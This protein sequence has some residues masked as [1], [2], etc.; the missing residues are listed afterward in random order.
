MSGLKNFGIKNFVLEIVRSEEFFVEKNIRQKNFGSKN[1]MSQKCLYLKL[2]SLEIFWSR[3][4]GSKQNFDQNKR[5]L[6]E[7]GGR[8]GSCKMGPARRFFI[9]ADNPRWSRVWQLLLTPFVG[10][11]D[12]VKPGNSSGIKKKLNSAASKYSQR[13]APTSPAPP[14][15]RA[16]PA[17]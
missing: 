5:F 6:T 13:T 8:V 1:F 7:L 2:L 3:K 4:F 17:P 12:I 9:F 10:R 11:V 14:C 15:P 16:P